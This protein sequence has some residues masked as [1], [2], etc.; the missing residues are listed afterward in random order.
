[1]AEIS[2]K[3]IEKERICLER[4]NKTKTISIEFEEESLDPAEVREKTKFHVETV[5]FVAKKLK[6]FLKK[7]GWFAVPKLR[8]TGGS[9]KTTSEKRCSMRDLVDDFRFYLRQYFAENC[10]KE[11]P[12]FYYTT[13]TALFQMASTLGFRVVKPQN[14]FILQYHSF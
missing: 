4:K 1:M 10:E 5:S 6:E 2:A 3:T 13:Q 9:L 12:A 8:N 14:K 11:V 7:K